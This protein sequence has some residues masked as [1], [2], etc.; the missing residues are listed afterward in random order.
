MGALGVR[1]IDR[2]VT[3][4]RWGDVTEPAVLQRSALSLNPGGAAFVRYRPGRLVVGR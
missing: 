4:G 2:R 1:A 3:T